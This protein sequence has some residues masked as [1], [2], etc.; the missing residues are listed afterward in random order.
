MSPRV[1]AVDP[2]CLAQWCADYLG[3]PPAGELFRSGYLSAVIGLRLADD[4]EVVVKVRPRSPRIA[5][6]VEVHRRLFESGY[7]CPEPL[8]GAAPLGDGVATAEAYVAGGA[9]LPGAARSAWAFAEAFAR[10]ITLAPRPAEVS[11]LDPPPSWAAWSQTGPGLWP[12]P[13]DGDVNLNDVAGP[14]W[15]DDAGR[16]AR[17]RLHASASEVV[18]G[19]CDWLAGNLRWSG[20]T[21]LVVHDWDSVTADSEAVLVG[22]AAALYSTVNPDELATVEETEQ[23]LVAYRDARGREFSADELERSWAAGCWTRAYDAKYQHAAGQ[24]VRSLTENQARERLRRA[25][26][27]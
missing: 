3:S 26:T 20:D 11:A 6:C 9:M 4:R 5:A 18:I 1:P 22:L 14:V 25:G 23:F 15:I 2:A 21:L 24:P 16:C 27:A 19:H 7:P 8:T 12:H 17:D 13:E 10:L